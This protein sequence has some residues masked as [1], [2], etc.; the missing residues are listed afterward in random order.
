VGH[1]LLAHLRGQ[2]DAVRCLVRRDSD[3]AAVATTGATVVRGGLED[4]DALERLV[5]GADVVFHVAGLVAAAS[6]AAFVAVNRDG[7]ARVAAA[8]RAAGARLVHVSSLA[9]TGPSVPGLPL[10]EA[11]PPSP[12]SS[13]GRSKRDAEEAVR[14]SG[15][16]FTIVRPAI[17]YGPRD[18]QTLRLFRLARLGLAPLPGG[19]TQELSLVHAHDLAL[20]LDAVSRV[21]VTLG[22]TYHAAHREP[23]TQRALLQE[24]GRAVGRRVRALPLPP[25]VVRAALRVGG[26]AARLRGAATLLDADKAA[27]ILAPAWV[28]STDALTRDTGW[29]AT[30]PHAAGLAATA[31]WYE[32]AGWL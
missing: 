2:R 32:Q 3:A 18:R 6:P 25:F 27:E 22:R 8:A 21:A 4:E 10:D 24:V 26:A 13:Y 14:A 11:H 23:L 17:V 5:A 15:A 1:H 16:S 7:T 9:V 20:A 30:T 12:V 31:R 29:Q 28:C 19:G